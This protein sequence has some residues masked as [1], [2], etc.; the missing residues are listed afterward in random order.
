MV[1]DGLE[2]NVGSA[3]HHT[4][5]VCVRAS[6]TGG[7]FTLAEQILRPGELEE[8]ALRLGWLNVLNPFQPDHRY[9]LDLSVSR[10][11]WPACPLWGAKLIESLP[12]TPE[13]G[14]SPYC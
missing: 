10:A 4:H 13:R 1:Y 2:S 6:A 7:L 11:A 3:E 12:M 9:D 5:Y 8:Y 14:A